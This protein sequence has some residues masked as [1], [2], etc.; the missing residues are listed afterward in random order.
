MNNIV[1]NLL[2]LHFSARKLVRLRIQ[3]QLVASLVILVVEFLLRSLGTL[4]HEHFHL[5]A[6]VLSEVFI[7]HLV[8]DESLSV[9]L[10]LGFF[11]VISQSLWSDHLSLTEIL[12]SRDGLALP[13]LVQPA[14]RPLLRRFIRQRVSRIHRVVKIQ[15]A[16]G[17][18]LWLGRFVLLAPLRRLN[19]RAMLL[20]FPMLIALRP[21]TLNAALLG[22]L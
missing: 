21:F 17:S 18:G 12:G 14:A 19:N 22:V 6:I 7:T 4:R 20:L 2:L 3:L 8:V 9:R 16:V 11:F 1:V 13:L 10:L 5:V 15:L